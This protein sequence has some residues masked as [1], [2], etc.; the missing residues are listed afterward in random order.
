[1]FISDNSFFSDPRKS[2]LIRGKSFLSDPGDVGDYARFR[3]SGALLGSFRSVLSVFIRG[4]VFLQKKKGRMR[5]AA[6]C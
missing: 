6:P 5:G 2:A 1:V 4:E 3:R